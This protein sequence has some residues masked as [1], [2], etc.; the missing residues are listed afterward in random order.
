M[1][2]RRKSWSPSV[3]M[4]PRSIRRLSK[5][6]SRRCSD[7]GASHGD[8]VELVVSSANRQTDCTSTIDVVMILKALS[9]PS[10]FGQL[11]NSHLMPRIFKMLTQWMLRTLVSSLSSFIVTSSWY[12]RPTRLW[13]I[14]PTTMHWVKPKLSCNPIRML[15]LRCQ[16]L[17]GWKPCWYFCARISRFGGCLGLWVMRG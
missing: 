5:R 1:R 17:V 10:F 4:W 3:R 7:Q 11:F 6:C 2:K 15:W 9:D 8:W 12:L 14:W 16:S 13:A